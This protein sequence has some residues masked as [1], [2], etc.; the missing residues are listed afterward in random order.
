MKKRI[1]SLLRCSDKGQATL[2]F[3]IIIP[4]LGLFLLLITY[5][6]WWTYL[7]LAAQNAAYSGTIFMPRERYGLAG[8]TLA[9]LSTL[10]ADEGMKQMWESSTVDI[11]THGQYGW[12]R[13]GGSGMTVYVSAL[14]WSDFWEIF[15]SVGGANTPRGTAFSMYSPFMSAGSEDGWITPGTLKP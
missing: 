6:G 7:K 10:H 1:L 5:T 15:K 14:A 4:V 2:E 12:S 13:R 11:Y 9:Q 3:V 8:N